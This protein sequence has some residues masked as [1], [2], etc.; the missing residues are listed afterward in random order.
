MKTPTVR[1]V[2]F[3]DRL[4]ALTPRERVF[5]LV[6]AAVLAFFLLWLLFLRGAEE[7]GPVELAD[8]PPPPAAV[9]PPSIQ[10]ISVA[11]PPALPVVTAPAAPTGSGAGLSLQGVSGGGPSGGA[12]LIQYQ[13]GTQRLV[14]VGREIAP[15]MVLKSVGLTHVIA[16]SGGGDVRLDLNRPGA[17]AVAATAMA[18]PPPAIIPPALQTEKAETLGLRLGLVPVTTGGRIS[19]YTVR[20]GA[21][22]SRLA[23]AGLQ[24]GDTITRVNGSELDEERLLELSSQMSSSER[25]DLEV[26]RGGKKMKLTFVLRPLR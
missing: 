1:T 23:A 18:S 21:G 16:S 26:I 6:G 12:A 13:T 14:R 7:D 10:P 5:L 11:P 19:G 15:G 3:S 9:A 24:S 4:A 20:P 17:T 25:M 22:L 8:A 2:S